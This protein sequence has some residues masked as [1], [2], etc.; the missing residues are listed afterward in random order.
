MSVT[1]APTRSLGPPEAAAAQPSDLAY[2]RDA[3][4]RVSRTFAINIRVLGGTMGGVVR[5]AY[6]LCRTADTLEDAWTGSPAETSGH[7]DQF[8]A[9]IDGDGAAAESLSR[10]AA[11]FAT[12]GA[13]FDL[14]AHFP[15]V[16]RAFRSLENGDRD[17]VTSGVRTLADGMKRYA[18]RAALRGDPM[19]HPYLETEAELHDYCWIV[20]GCVG[21]M[22]TRLF[23]RRATPVD[24]ARLARRIELAPAVGEA[25]QLTNILLDWPND[26]R[27]GRCYLPSEWLAEL[28]LR[29]PDLLDPRRREIATLR[30]RLE[31]LARGALARV[32]DYLDTIPARHVRYRQFC[33]WPALW[34]L[35][36]LRR[37]RGDSTFPSGYTR[38]KLS[39]RELWSIAA[40]SAALGHSPRAVRALFRAVGG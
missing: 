31:T 26:L 30:D 39:K 21:V 6:L 1:A 10:Q 13:D 19:T 29:P 40:A 9:A 11:A 3:L 38:P 23:S 34:A 17:A 25:L 14:V 16:W 33:L 22:L 12:R 2:C 36:S 18:V 20:A 8:L 35:G 7:F 15:R 27:R 37:A 28:G 32:P 5:I 4:P 24:S